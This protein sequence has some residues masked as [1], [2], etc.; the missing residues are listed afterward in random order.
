[1]VIIS[2]WSLR[3]GEWKPLKS[4]IEF[5]SLG[6]LCFGVLGVFELATEGTTAARMV[7]L[8]LIF[9]ATGLNILVHF[10]EEALHKKV[11]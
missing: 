2:L 11:K 8:L 7:T 5:V 9:A 1:V 4:L 10:K 6:L 3:K